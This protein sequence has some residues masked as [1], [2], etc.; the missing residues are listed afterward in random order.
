MLIIEFYKFINRKFNYFYFLFIFLFLSFVSFKNNYIIKFLS[1]DNYYFIYNYLLIFLLLSVIF[2]GVFN[3]ISS[4]REDYKEKTIKIIV[5][6]KVTNFKNIFSKLFIITFFSFIFYLVIFT[7]ILSFYVYKKIVK[8]SDL[9]NL[10]KVYYLLLIF[11]V[12]IF[13]NVLVLLFVST[14]NNFNLAIS[15]FLLFLIGSKFLV[16]YLKNINVIFE[17]LEYTFLDINNAVF[18]YLTLTFTEYYSLKYSLILFIN[19]FLLFLFV[20]LIN[21]LRFK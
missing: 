7:S 12:I 4:Y 13:V 10:E 2:L 14:F 3:M 19:S 9:L 21:K 18:K 11:L 17:K 15:F 1:V 6:S 16:N 8:F 5:N 20:L